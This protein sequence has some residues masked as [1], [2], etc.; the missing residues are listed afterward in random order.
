MSVFL[1][2][3]AN[4][5]IGLE[6]CRQLKSR[7]ET[8]VAVCREASDELRG[9]DVRIE[10][11]PD[12]S[13]QQSISDLVARLNGLE[14]N[15]AILNAG[16]NHVMDLNSLDPVS[17]RQQFDVNALAPLL[18]ANALIPSMSSGGKLLFMSSRMGSI[19]D[20]SSGGEYGYR[21]SKA[22]LNSAVKSLSIDLKDQGISVGVLHPGMVQTRMNLTSDGIPP[23]EAVANLLKRVDQLSLQTT[24]TFWHAD[25]TVLPW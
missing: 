12:L 11:I 10:Q 7:G 18:L 25:G 9:L 22:A 14:I 6:Y 8:V 24:G 13:Q 16:I 23:E 5:G 20:N 17:I 4:R 2:T 1:V 15:A 21:M 19:Q 3:G